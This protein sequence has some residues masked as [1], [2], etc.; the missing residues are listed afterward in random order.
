MSPKPASKTSGLAIEIREGQRLNIYDG[1]SV[2]TP[3]I[4]I[5]LEHKQGRSAR[6]RIV[7]GPDIVLDLRGERLK[8]PQ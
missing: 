3:R 5:N 2:D 6:L 7:S 8:V 1:S 4:V